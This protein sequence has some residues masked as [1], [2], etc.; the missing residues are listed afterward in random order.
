[1]PDKKFQRL[2]DAYETLRQ[3]G[4]DARGIETHDELVEQFQTLRQEYKDQSDGKAQIYT[5]I[6]RPAFVAVA[7]ALKNIHP[8][9][10]GDENTLVC[11]RSR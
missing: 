10:H 1:M 9:L 2:S 5:E 3:Y 8:V 7:N 4:F 6:I 11:R